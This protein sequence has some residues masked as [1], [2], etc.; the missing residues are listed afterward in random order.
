SGS[1]QASSPA[2]SAKTGQ[3]PSEA[4][5]KARV[6]S[7]VVLVK[8]E[9]RDVADASVAYE[10]IANPWL[11]KYL[12]ASTSSSP[13]GGAPGGGRGGGGQGSAPPG[14][15]GGSGGGAMPGG[16][17]PG[18]GGGKG[19]TVTWT[20]LGNE[21]IKA[22]GGDQTKKEEAKGTDLHYKRTEFVV[23][24]IWREP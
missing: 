15:G 8:V 16:G 20:A 12:A 14:G 3:P 6:I 19:K 7:H 10:Y 2:S 5:Q 4:D 13:R 23:L 9:S 11:E 18:M 17:A 22:S 24:F 21:T 1:E